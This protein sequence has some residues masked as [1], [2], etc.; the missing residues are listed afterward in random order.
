MNYVWYQFPGATTQTHTVHYGF[1]VVQICI[2]L[3]HQ[4]WIFYYLLRG[5]LDQDQMSIN[6]ITIT[7]I[8]L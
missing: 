2:S 4:Y 7:N 5:Y 8:I 1:I 6:L 3:P